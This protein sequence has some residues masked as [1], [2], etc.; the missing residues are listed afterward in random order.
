MKPVRADDDL[1]GAVARH[2]AT[3]TREGLAWAALAALLFAAAS[4]SGNNLLY[5]VLCPVLALG[6]VDGLL[7][8]WH[9]R[10][11]SVS[12][13]LPDEVFAGH[14]ASG[15][16]WVRNR[17]RVGSVAGVWLED[18]AGGAR[19][20]VHD[21]A[22]GEERGARV[23]WG[24]R[25][26][27]LVELDDVVLRSLFPFGLVRHEVRFHLPCDVVV[28]PHPLPDPH[29]P[30]GAWTAAAGE[31]AGRLADVDAD[32]AGLRP[33]VPGDSLRAVHWPTSARVGSPVVVVRAG[34]AGRVVVDVHDESGPA[35]ERELSRAA[36]E[37]V[38]ATD[39]GLGVD[40]RLPDGSVLVGDGPRGRRD[41]LERLALLP[42]RP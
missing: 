30:A 14:D 21:V 38:R 3:P 8:R 10:G 18:V 26:R 37:V 20:V 31:Q 32:I 39:A 28:Y 6:L 15:R 25:E 35:Y 24:F 16:L 27:G 11:L 7:G 4:L 13:E 36:G 22:P 33:W 40:V 19:G 1:D 9:V 12:R 17:R 5:L 2:R 42:R 41:V 29:R 34:S 23:S